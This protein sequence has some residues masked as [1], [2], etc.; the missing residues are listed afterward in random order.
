MSVLPGWPA[1]WLTAK[2]M[3]RPSWLNT[4]MVAGAG[5]AAAAGAAAAAP[6]NKPANGSCTSKT[7]KEQSQRS[8]AILALRVLYC[9]RP[10]RSTWQGNG[11]GRYSCPTTAPANCRQFRHNRCTQRYSPELTAGAAVA[12]AGAGAGA[13]PS[14]PSM[15]TAAAGA[16]AVAGAG[17]GGAGPSRSSKPP[18]AGAAAAPPSPSTSSR[19]VLAAAG[20][21]PLVDTLPTIAAATSRPPSRSTRSSLAGAAAGAAPAPAAAA[22]APSAAGPGAAPPEDMGGDATAPLPRLR[23]YS[24]SSS[25]GMRSSSCGVM[26][27]WP[28]SILLYSQLRACT[29]SRTLPLWRSTRADRR[30]TWAQP[31]AA[32]QGQS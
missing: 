11:P 9:H 21:A 30:G 31:A 24:A 1:G 32:R 6:P 27:A 12:G 15:S 23:E 14:M 25:A 3:L 8:C 26:A 13:S 2:L 19:G 10:C 7:S 4:G 20:A 29:S 22:A 16:A 17:A 18:T 5:P 28:P